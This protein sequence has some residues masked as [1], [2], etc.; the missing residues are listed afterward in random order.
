MNHFDREVKANAREAV[1]S[2]RVAL[3]ARPPSPLPCSPSPQAR[4]F[5]IEIFW[6][7]IFSKNLDRKI[8][9]EKIERGE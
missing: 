6:I 4:I 5:W 1:S 8:W 7:E 9:I 3:K 2:E